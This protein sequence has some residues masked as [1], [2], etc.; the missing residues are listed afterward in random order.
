[1]R[2]ITINVI[3]IKNINKNKQTYM[4]INF[5]KLNYS[6]KGFKKNAMGPQNNVRVRQCA[7]FLVIC[8]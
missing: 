7:A 8:S 2:M 4:V 6:F 3:K 1:M 5:L